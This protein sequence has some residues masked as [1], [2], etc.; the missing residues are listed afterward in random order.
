MSD[1]QDQDNQFDEFE[2]SPG[3]R[4]EPA[5]GNRSFLIAIGVIGGIFVI[6]L[7]ALAVVLLNRS[8]QQASQTRAEVERINAQNTAVAAT[9]TADQLRII[10]LQQTL[11][12]AA[13]APPPSATPT[14][15]P[16][17]SG[18]TPTSV[19]AIPTATNTPTATI[20][21][22]MAATATSSAATQFAQGTKTLGAGGFRGTAYPAAQTAAAGTLAASAGTLQPTST[23]LPTTGFAD[24]IGLPGLLGLAA[25]LVVVVFLARRARFS[26][27]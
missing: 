19:V 13:K 18:G 17:A 24:E 6:A 21:A 9:A 22:E 11:D 15:A 20:S 1:F 16:P 4:P 10:A 8:P 25:L 2:E 5:K 27:H 7:I 12:A 26:A 14:T 3:S 23:A